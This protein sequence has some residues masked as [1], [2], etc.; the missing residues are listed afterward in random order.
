MLHWKFKGNNFLFFRNKIKN[1]KKLAVFVCLFIYF[2]I[3]KKNIFKFVFKYMLN[4][5]VYDLSSW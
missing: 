3:F 4:E 1:N 5:L 2:F